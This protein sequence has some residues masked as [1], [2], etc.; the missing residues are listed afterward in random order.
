MESTG[1]EESDVQTYADRLAKRR[2]VR[3]VSGL[4]IEKNSGASADASQRIMDKFYRA[5]R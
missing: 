1:I 5:I 3:S 2:I 4:K